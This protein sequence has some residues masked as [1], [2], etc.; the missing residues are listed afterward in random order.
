[1]GTKGAGGYYLENTELQPTYEVPLPPEDAAAGTDTQLLKA[2]EVMLEKV[3][4]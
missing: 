3:G 4:G 1:M 2:V